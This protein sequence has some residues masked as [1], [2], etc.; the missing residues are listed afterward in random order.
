M[1]IM[2]TPHLFIVGNPLSGSSMLYRLLSYHRDLAW[3]SQWTLR[4]GSTGP[5]RKKIPFARVLDKEGRRFEHP[6]SKTT[7]MRGAQVVYLPRDS[8][9]RRWRRYMGMGV[10]RP[11]SGASI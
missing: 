7:Y 9:T 10:S 3:F 11:A 6:W 5:E 1:D 8:V 4:D 2:I